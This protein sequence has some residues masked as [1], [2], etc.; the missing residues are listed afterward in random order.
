MKKRR[1]AAKD[2][3]AKEKLEDGVVLLIDEYDNLFQYFS[4]DEAITEIIEDN[5]NEFFKETKSLLAEVPQ[6]NKVFL[7][8]LK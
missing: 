7:T 6:F 1:D 2:D 5:M 3:K 8:T 4:Q